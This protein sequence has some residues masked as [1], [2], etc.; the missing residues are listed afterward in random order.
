MVLTP[1]PRAAA[2]PAQCLVAEMICRHHTARQSQSLRAA[3]RR[4]GNRDRY[5][6]ASHEARHRGSC[7][8]PHFRA[9]PNPAA[10]GFGPY[11]L[12]PAAQP[13]TWKRPRFAGSDT[14]VECIRADTVPQGRVPGPLRPNAGRQPRTFSHVGCTAL[15]GPASA[16]RIEAAHGS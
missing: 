6:F 4:G 2:S 11:P 13:T 14:H 12:R 7:C 15:F 3:R 10:P 1:I 9:E 5:I 8:R 16:R